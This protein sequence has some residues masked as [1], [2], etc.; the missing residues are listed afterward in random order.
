MAGDPGQTRP[1]LAYDLVGYHG[2]GLGIAQATRNT[3]EALRA[4]GRDV[5]LVTVGEVR[6][7]RPPRVS[8]S[9]GARG[10]TLFEM[11]PLDIAALGRQWAGV[12]DPGAP[13]ACIPFWELPRLPRAWLP[14]LRAMQVVLAPTRFVEGACREA[15]PGTVVL[16]YP[17]AVFPPPEV[18]PARAEWGIAEGVTAFLVAFD[19]GSDIE[20]KNPWAAATAFQAAF[21]P[22]TGGVELIFKVTLRD[23]LPG[24]RAQVA[25][26]RARAADDARIRIIDRWLGYEELLRL[27]ASCD[28]MISLHRSEGLGLHLMEAMSLAKPVVATG[29]SGNMDFM[30]STN[31]VLVGHH[32]V[33]VAS[34][35]VAYRAEVGREG[36]VWA[37][38]DLRAAADALRTLHASPERRRAIG[39]AADRD[40]E[41]RRVEMRAGGVFR[42]LEAVVDGRPG[43]PA[44][45]RRALGRSMAH[46]VWRKV[47]EIMGR[48]GNRP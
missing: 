27:Y 41:R 48:K 26:L 10:I 21:P 47:G 16:H 8:H 13:A 7:E 33:P 12:I 24:Y 1:F 29:W 40:M 38:P 6:A 17:Q 32:L 9:P 20:R 23:H 14:V 4:S 3:A 43:T 2:G 11:N 15:L 35:H 19:V 45:L 44:R 22:G 28:V 37:E 25:E 31:A 46:L 30:D 18:G 5:R 36:Q 39:A 34:R 42:D